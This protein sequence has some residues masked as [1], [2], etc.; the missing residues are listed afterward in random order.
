MIIALNDS[1]YPFLEQM[2][3]VPKMFDRL[4]LDFT[5]LMTL[6][7]DTSP[8][9]CLL[10]SNQCFNA[11]IKFVTGTANPHYNENICFQR[12]C[13]FNEFAVVK[14]LFLAE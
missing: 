9:G 6:I 3:M 10:L 2:C 5:G 8:R 14:N 12:R 11:S 13:H 1:N 7:V 4:K